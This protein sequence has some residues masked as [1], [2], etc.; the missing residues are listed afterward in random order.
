MD[1]SELQEIDKKEKDGS[2]LSSV[3]HDFYVKLRIAI[4]S[5]RDSISRDN[6]LSAREYENILMISKRIL[7]RRISKISFFA[8]RNLDLENMTAEESQL[9]SAISSS[10]KALTDMVDK[11]LEDY[12]PEPKKEIARDGG[13]AKQEPPQ[14]KAAIRERKIRIV[15]FV[16][17]YKG[18][19]GA[20]YGPFSIGIIIS[21]MGREEMDW[22]VEEGYAEEI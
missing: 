11:G 6:I 15:K 4:G 22:L 5:K 3:P 18:L 12:K 14:E 20:E 8:S 9:Y 21:D 7:S 17:A 19:D 16:D 13:D 1:L 10:A 2:G